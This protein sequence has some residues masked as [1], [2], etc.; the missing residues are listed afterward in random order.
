MVGTSYINFLPG[1]VNALAG[2]IGFTDIEAGQIVALNI[3]GALAGCITAIFILKKVSWKSTMLCGLL[4]LALFDISTVW[5][6]KYSRMLFCR[7][8][9]GLVGGLCMGISFSILARLAS[10]D[11]AFGALL[12]TQFAIC[13]AVMA[14]LPPL[15]T[16]LGYYAVF[17][18]MAS[19]SAISM[20]ILSRLPLNNL[21]SAPSAAQLRSTRNINVVS[22]MIALMIYLSAANAIW[23]YIGRIGINAGIS[24]QNV[25]QYIAITSL[26]GLL[27]ALLPV[28]SGKR[29][30]RELCILIGISLSVAAV[31]FLNI[32]PFTSSNYL[33]AM[34]LIFFAWPA[35]N[36]YLLALIADLD[37]TGRL[38]SVAAL[39]SLCGAATGPMMASALI[40]PT[41]FSLM[42]QSCLVT[43]LISA[44]FALSPAIGK[45]KGF[46]KSDHHQ[47]NN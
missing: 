25:S 7:F 4:L 1:M 17:Y 31:Y 39:V 47:M 40:E 11:R 9:A 19:F 36:S 18:V 23:T 32:S 37:L 38:S 29:L 14:A 34:C 44:L 2:G 21:K 35:V 12:F 5:I 3:Y 46:F 30:G 22:F 10:P 24:E 28:L 41:G 43:F 20:F 33:L 15:E 16:W 13:F 42:L 6:D 27:G 8:G 26:L 45:T